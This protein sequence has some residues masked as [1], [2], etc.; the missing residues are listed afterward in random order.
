[1]FRLET[2][3]TKLRQAITDCL[4]RGLIQ[5]A[6]WA[7]E[8]LNYIE[9]NQKNDIEFQNWINEEKKSVNNMVLNLSQ[10]I[11]EQKEKLDGFGF[12]M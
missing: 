6:K 4:D 5:S 12:Y 11:E 2:E 3:R 8:Q 7:A 1:M 10:E 9:I